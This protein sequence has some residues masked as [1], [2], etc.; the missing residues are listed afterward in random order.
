MEKS[1]TTGKLF[2]ALAKA[3]GDMPPAKLDCENTFLKTKYASLS[4]IH[5]AYK[6]VLSSNGLCVTQ[7]LEATTGVDVVYSLK[8][9]LGHA[10][11]EWIMARHPIIVETNKENEETMQL[12]GAA[13][14]Y[15]RRQSICSLLGIV[16]A[17]DDSGVRQAKNVVSKQNQSWQDEQKK[18]MEEYDRN[19]ASTTMPPA[20]TAATSIFGGSPARAH[21]VMPEVTEAIVDSY[22]VDFGKDQGKKFGDLPRAL[23]A[24]KMRFLENEATKPLNG[25]MTTFCKLA[26]IYLERPPAST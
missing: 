22:V 17:E 11:G 24:D 15:G 21:E 2:E 19:K 14:T 8:T 7:M 16:E 20:V 12:L 25:K 3:Q 10:S 23:I 13:I 9:V 1:E 26:K 6:S 5:A 18:K 4:S